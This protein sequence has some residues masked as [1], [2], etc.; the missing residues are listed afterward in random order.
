[1]PAPIE[2]PSG[3]AP[4]SAGSSSPVI[5][6][7]LWIVNVRLRAGRA[8]VHPAP[9]LEALASERCRQTI[10]AIATMPSVGNTSSKG[11]GAVYE[12]SAM[13]VAPESLNS[14]TFQ[15][16]GRSRCVPQGTSVAPIPR[17]SSRKERPRPARTAGLRRGIPARGRP[18]SAGRSAVRT[19][20]WRCSPRRCRLSPRTG[21]SA[22]WPTRSSGGAGAQESGG[23]ACPRRM[24]APSARETG[25]VCP[26]VKSSMAEPAQ[27][28][29]A[30]RAKVT[31]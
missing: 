26:I 2:P 18:N 13:A 8:G 27:G 28:A 6:C 16:E 7:W 14:S 19:R 30:G 4:G 3:M 23:P 21:S 10:G 22:W 1:M 17:Q 24:V 5:T 12:P 25:G 15:V 9:V 31:W 20:R 11:G 29:I